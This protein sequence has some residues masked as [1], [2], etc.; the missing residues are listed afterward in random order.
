VLQVQRWDLEL[1]SQ[2]EGRAFSH[3]SNVNIGVS[4]LMIDIKNKPNVF[5][6]FNNLP[7]DLYTPISSMCGSL[8]Q[9][10]LRQTNKYYQKL[11]PFPTCRD[12]D[13]D[14]FKIT[15]I[16][17]NS[18][19]K[20]A[21]DPL[22]LTT[23]EADYLAEVISQRPN[24]DWHFLR[25]TRS[26]LDKFCAAWR[27]KCPERPVNLKKCLLP[28]YIIGVRPDSSRTSFKYAERN[29]I[30][31]NLSDA[32]LSDAVFSG[33]DFI[34]ANLNRAILRNTALQGTNF[35]LSTLENADFNG[36]TISSS[37][38]FIHTIQYRPAASRSFYS[39]NGNS[40]NMQKMNI[41]LNNGQGDSPDP[42]NLS[43]ADAA[44]LAQIIFP[45]RNFD[46]HYLRFTRND[47][48]NFC[49]AWRKNYPEYPVNLK[50]CF[51]PN[52]ENFKNEKKFANSYN[53]WNITF[54]KINLSNVELCDSVL[55][56]IN[57]RHSILQGANL[58]NTALHGTIFDNCDLS[59]TNFSGATITAS[60]TFAGA[61]ITA[62]TT[63][64]SP[65]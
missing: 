43:E 61:T 59:G 15:T 57:F 64:D 46:W 12:E 18:R 38:G 28:V 1:F 50:K 4:V 17:R 7:Q 23:K 51:L 9:I 65:R 34:S 44:Y 27:T 21:P 25:F 10:A 32:D 5:S 31:C 42:L 39:L 40:V 24:F 19:K 20:C 16:L 35:M 26:D 30:R 3:Y 8:E 33:V 54:N 63:F 11:I 6:F 58:Q 2:G 52:E 45:R 62:S 36:A 60:T 55:N 41:I 53:K 56:G 29:F 13:F 37:T 48:E 47:L 14:I 22:K 49:A